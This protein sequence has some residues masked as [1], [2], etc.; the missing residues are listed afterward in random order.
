MKSQMS[1]FNEVKLECYD[2]VDY[3]NS[4]TPILMLIC[5][6]FGVLVFSK[7]GK[8]LGNN[9]K[10]NKTQIEFTIE[11]FKEEEHFFS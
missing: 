7:K 11:N 3:I 9:D 4:I 2:L 6:L 10:I 8:A 5:F 1:D